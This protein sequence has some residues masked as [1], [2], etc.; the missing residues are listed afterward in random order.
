MTNQPETTKPEA[1][2]GAGGQVERVVSDATHVAHW[3]T[4]PVYACETHA[5]QIVALGRFM[6][7]H[8]AVTSAEPGHECSNCKNERG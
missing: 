6:G 2:T 5:N 3:A 7:T 8:V 4:G 1:P